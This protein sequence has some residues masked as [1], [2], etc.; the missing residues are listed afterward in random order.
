MRDVSNVLRHR[1]QF[2]RISK[3]MIFNHCALFLLNLSHPKEEF[4]FV[5][6]FVQR[7]E[8]DSNFQPLN[9]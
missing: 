5:K 2:V 6:A 7:N 3:R 1:F 4:E 9:S 8:N